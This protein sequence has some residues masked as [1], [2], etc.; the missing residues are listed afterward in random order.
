[1]TQ[2]RLDVKRGS[3]VDNLKRTEQNEIRA[4]IVYGLLGTELSTFVD[5][6]NDQ[7]LDFIVERRYRSIQRMVSFINP[8]RDRKILAYP[9]AGPVTAQVNKQSRSL[10]EGVTSFSEWTEGFTRSCSLNRAKLAA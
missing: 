9:P 5:F 1:M 2:T 4:R 6:S 3:L 10:W 8:S 7:L